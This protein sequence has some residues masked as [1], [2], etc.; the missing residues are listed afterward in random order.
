MG[1]DFSQDVVICLCVS[2]N[3]SGQAL[4]II[5]VTYSHKYA[6]DSG[7]CHSRKTMF[8]HLV[9]SQYML[10]QLPSSSNTT[11]TP[12]TLGDSGSVLACASAKGIKASTISV[13]RLPLSRM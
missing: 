4:R 9:P 2:Y 12:R 7:V 13:T 11:I 5:E 1:A 3:E 10:F 6:I 8:I